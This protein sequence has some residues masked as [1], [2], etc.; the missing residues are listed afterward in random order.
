M[1]VKDIMTR[2]VIAVKNTQTVDEVKE[3]F[4]EESITG[5]PVLNE[6]DDLVGIVTVND[7]LEA[8]SAKDKEENRRA[9]IEDFMTKS[10]LTADVES[11]VLAVFKLMR[12]N[13][14][15]RLV[16]KKNGKLKGI[17]ST[18]DAYRALLRIVNKPDLLQKIHKQ[19]K[20]RINE[21]QNI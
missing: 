18:M 20:D 8:Y 2:T 21:F 9:K 1:K 17:I 16:V 19:E 4:R 3:K 7:L 13:H 15:H 5:A 12:D 6:K 14:I 10:V 11:D